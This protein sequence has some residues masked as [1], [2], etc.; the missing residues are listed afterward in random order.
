MLTSGHIHMH[1]YTHTHEQGHACRHTNSKSRMVMSKYSPAF[2]LNTFSANSH[3]VTSFKCLVFITLGCVC[4]WYA[5]VQRPEDDSKYPSW[6]I[7]SSYMEAGTHLSTELTDSLVELAMGILSLPLTVVLTNG[8]PHL[9]S[10]FVGAGDLNKGKNLI[11]GV[12]LL[13]PVLCLL[14]RIRHITHNCPW[15]FKSFK[16]GEF[17]DRLCS[18]EH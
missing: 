14:C 1:T 10:I 2:Y 8:L 9:C 6:L 4:A 11:H 7:S 16:D 15:L 3:S 5:C 12:I 17:R 13:V 18:S